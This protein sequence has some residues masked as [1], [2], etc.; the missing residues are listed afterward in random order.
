MEVCPIL[1]ARGD[2]QPTKC[3]V[4]HAGIQAGTMVRAMVLGESA[5]PA[6]A[7]GGGGGGAMLH[8]SLKASMGGA[9]AGR[10]GDD[11][12]DPIISPAALA[13]ASAAPALPAV[14]DQVC[15]DAPG[16]ICHPFK[17]S[18]HLVTLWMHFPRVHCYR[19]GKIKIRVLIS[20]RCDMSVTG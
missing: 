6:S 8:L 9:V 18:H 19:L 10:P 20:R 3:G 13:S 5:V 16:A 4:L 12:A 14:G 11:V 7:G 1:Y 17:I 2:A 15:T